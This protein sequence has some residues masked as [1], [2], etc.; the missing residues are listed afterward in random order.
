MLAT[1][2]DLFATR[3][4]EA[5]NLMDISEAAG[6]GRTTFYHY[7]GSK[8]A[9]LERLVGDLTHG[10]IALLDNVSVRDDASSSRQL[11]EVVSSLAGRLME[12]PLQFKVIDRNLPALPV[13]IQSRYLAARQSIR[14]LL[15]R[16]IAKGTAANEFRSVDPALH[17]LVIIGM[18]SR[19]IY[20]LEDVDHYSRAEIVGVIAELALKGLQNR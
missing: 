1:A 7:F 20:W 5:T 15:T 2:A 4:Y 9:I 6:V 14:S 13:E 19:S 16:I 10:L 18:C 11:Y 12:H 17:A 8:E 3:G